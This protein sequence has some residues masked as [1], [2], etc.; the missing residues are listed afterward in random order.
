MVKKSDSKENED[1]IEE[2]FYLRVI[3]FFHIS[4]IIE[5]SQECDVQTHNK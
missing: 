5:N 4:Y 1:R 2:Y 3:W